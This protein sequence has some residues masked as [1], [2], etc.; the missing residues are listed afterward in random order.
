MRFLPALK[1]LIMISAIS[2]GVFVTNTMALDLDA[3]GFRNDKDCDTL[4][5][6]RNSIAKDKQKAT[7]IKASSDR[8]DMEIYED[9]LARWSLVG[10]NKKPK[11]KYE[12]A[13]VLM[14][15]PATRPYRSQV[16]YIKFFAKRGP[17]A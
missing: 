17:G 13:C 12:Q 15:G 1:R 2:F 6:I 14:S 10:V 7:G 3:D 16:F 9:D 5:V 4:E 8:W 11:D